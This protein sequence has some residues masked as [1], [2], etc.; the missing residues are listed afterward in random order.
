MTGGLNDDLTAQVMRPSHAPS[1][2]DTFLPPTHSRAHTMDE[3]GRSASDTFT[4]G[5]KHLDALL[6]LCPAP[7]GVD[8]RTIRQAL[9]QVEFGCPQVDPS[10]AAARRQ[11][12]PNTLVAIS[13]RPEN[14]NASHKNS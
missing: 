5:R 6:E 2:V 4:D 7:L 13:G 1:Q 12:S 10:R 9:D 3:C 8:L 11:E 14:G